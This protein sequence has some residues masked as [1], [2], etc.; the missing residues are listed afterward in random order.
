MS[1]LKL[2]LDFIPNHTS[3]KHKWFKASENKTIADNVYSDYYIWHEGVDDGD[4]KT[5][6]PN[7]WVLV[8]T[9]VFSGNGIK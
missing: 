2:V 5:R 6:P 3:K 9:N 8:L 7:N 1:G 4:G